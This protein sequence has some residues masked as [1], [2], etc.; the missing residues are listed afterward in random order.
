MRLGFRKPK[1]LRGAKLP[2]DNKAFVMSLVTPPN[3]YIFHIV[4]N[5][6]VARLQQFRYDFKITF[7]AEEYKGCYLN[8]NRKVLGKTEIPGPI[9]HNSGE[10]ARFVFLGGCEV[11][12]GRTC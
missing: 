2:F 11:S 8:S 5:N 12:S 1:G 10:P 7:D 9:V 4:T 6:V 3:E